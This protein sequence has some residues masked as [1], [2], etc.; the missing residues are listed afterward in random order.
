[1]WFEIIKNYSKQKLE[2][3]KIKPP[4]G[5]KNEQVLVNKLPSVVL[6]KDCNC[7]LQNRCYL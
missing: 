5:R 7:H 4:I 3:K 2:E 1:M 6:G